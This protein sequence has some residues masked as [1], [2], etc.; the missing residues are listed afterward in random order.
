MSLP[1]SPPDPTAAVYGPTPGISRNMT[2]PEPFGG[3]DVNGTGATTI[4]HGQAGTAAS[5]VATQR[6]PRTIS[7]NYCGVI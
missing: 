2:Q 4:L 1:T 3:G 7:P 5:R 6:V